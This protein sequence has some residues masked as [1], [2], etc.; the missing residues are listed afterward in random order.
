MLINNLF[1]EVFIIR[2]YNNRTVVALY[3]KFYIY[4]TARE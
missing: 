4:N 3:N 2:N 1:K